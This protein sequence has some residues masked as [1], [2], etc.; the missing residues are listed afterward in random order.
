[1]AGL[2]LKKVEYNHFDVLKK[3]RELYETEP[4][5]VRAPARINLIGEHTDYN[6]GFV[7]PA[8]IDKEIVFA[9]APSNDGISRIFSLNFQ[10]G[11]EVNNVEPEKIEK[12][13][14]ANYLLGVMRALRNKHLK[15]KPF[16]CVLGGNIPAGSGVSSSAALE[17]GFIFGLDEL[18]QLN[19]PKIELIK[20]A[21]WA[22][23]NYAG[24]NCG[25]MDQFASMMGKEGN[26]FVLDCRTLLYQYFPIELN[27]YTLVLLDTNV[28]HSL[29]DSEYNS[30]RKECEAG[31]SILKKHYPTITNLRDVSMDM[32]IKHRTEF[33]DITYNRCAYVV[34]E[35]ERVQKAS[36]DLAKGDVK[37]FGARMY[38]THDGLSKLYQVSCKELDFLV[39]EAKKSEYVLGARMMGG[40]FGGCTINIIKDDKLA[41]FIDQVKKRYEE[42]FHIEMNS[43]VVKVKNG[44]GKI[45]Y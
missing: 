44:T 25:I 35:I 26:V 16:N 20:M 38:E 19:Q 15:L 41:A 30:R 11:I 6:D 3:F 10:E 22:E 1:M 36:N 28:K 23:H 13:R 43:Y 4:L 27:G 32:L 12:P 45:M 8:A 17:C 34:A 40:G 9:L 5:L 14:W 37:S 18:N 29:A 39:D 7:M 24:V 31:V 42:T 33:S 21:Q 2:I